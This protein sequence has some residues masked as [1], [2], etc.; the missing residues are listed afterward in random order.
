[1]K[2]TFQIIHHSNKIK[3]YHRSTNP[4]QNKLNLFQFLGNGLEKPKMQKYRISSQRNQRI[5][6]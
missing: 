4:K 1:M 3:P 6:I 5:N 2:N